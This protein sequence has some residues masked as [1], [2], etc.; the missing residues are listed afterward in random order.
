MILI[1]WAVAKFVSQGY[2]SSTKS[3]M[4]TPQEDP[5]RPEYFPILK[6]NHV[7]AMKKPTCS[8]VCCYSPW[9]TSLTFL[10]C[11][12]RN[13]RKIQRDCQ[14]HIGSYWIMVNDISVKPE[15]LSKSWNVTILGWQVDYLLP[16]PLLIF[17]GPR[18]H[19]IAK[20]NP[21]ILHMRIG[22]LVISWHRLFLEGSEN[23]N[24]LVEH[25]LI[26]GFC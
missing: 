9:L 25:V 22:W 24:H 11:L 1:L 15:R 21:R 12:S 10:D 14:W 3:I 8:V 4:F 18:S 19:S 23:A 2:W 6:I 5:L 7:K 20:Q 17:H 13:W 16:I 26:L